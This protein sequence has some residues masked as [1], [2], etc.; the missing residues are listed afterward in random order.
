V[1]C[2][3]QF[4]ARLAGLVALAIFRHKFIFWIRGSLE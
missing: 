3:V 4:E 1:T 2:A